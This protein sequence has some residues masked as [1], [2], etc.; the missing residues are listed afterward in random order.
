MIKTLTKSN[1]AVISIVLALLVASVL[2]VI[3]DKSLSP[4]K[5]LD[6]TKQTVEKVINKKPKPGQPKPY[7]GDLPSLAAVNVRNAVLNEVYSGLKYPW[8][9]EFISADELLITEK[10]GQLK[11]LVLSTKK[12]TTIIGLPT[13]ASEKG[14]LGLMDVALHPDYRSN[15]LIYFSYATTNPKT[16]DEY[17]TAVSRAEL[18]EDSLRNVVQ[19]FVAT[20]YSKSA[21][22]LG[23]ALEFDDKGYL[24]IGAGDRAWRDWAANLQVL[25]GK[26]VR[27]NDDGSIPTDNPFVKAPDVQDAIYAYGVRNPQGLVF[28]KTTGLLY[29]TEHGPMGGD[30]VNT[31]NSGKNYGWPIIT[32]G[33]NYTTERIGVGTARDGLEQ[34]LFYYLPSIAVSPIA[35]YR[36]DMFPEWEGDLLVGAMRGQHINK[37]DVFKGVVKS[38][39]RILGEV[40]G[41]IRDIKVAI[42]GSIYVLVQ[43]GGR[44]F[45]LYRDP[46]RTDLEKVKQRNGKRVYQLVCA[47]CH[48]SGTRYIPQIGDT[49]AWQKRLQQGEAILYEHTLSGFNDMPERGH[50]DGCSDEEIKKAVDYMLNSLK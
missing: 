26:I 40:K 27:L 50:C 37:L 30:E 47:S 4:F 38:E 34:P 41:R 9:M 23:G 36:G 17:A 22:N 10:S 8:A 2:F 24:Y 13:I 28:D 1:A 3:Y 29:E 18:V 20:P 6:T 39:Q 25:N 19:I 5:L 48:S 7:F 49:E 21:S 42:D 14:Q 16:P 33:A 12:L 31:I 44:L 11:R 46:A 15:N 32:Y 35:I 43:N 45:R